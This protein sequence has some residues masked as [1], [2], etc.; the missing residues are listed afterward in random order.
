MLRIRTVN[1]FAYV[2]NAKP[3]DNGG[4]FRVA[5]SLDSSACYCQSGTDDQKR[6]PPATFR[7]QCQWPPAEVLS[8]QILTNPGC[9][10][11]RG[12]LPSAAHSD[13]P[14]P[15]RGGRSARHSIL[16]IDYRPTH[17]QIRKQIKDV[18]FF[19][20]IYPTASMKE[21]ESRLRHTAVLGKYRSSFNSVLF[22][23]E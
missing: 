2:G 16:N 18:A 4:Y 10:P 21:D 19:L 22:A 17:G 23:T 6:I 15:L 5:P 9:N 8:A 11:W 3:V 13:S 7:D 20:S 12:K 1:Q 14:R